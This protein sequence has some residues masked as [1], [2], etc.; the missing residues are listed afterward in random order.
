M[1]VSIIPWTRIYRFNK[2]QFITHGFKNSAV[3]S[4]S[5]AWNIIPLYRY[6]Y[7]Y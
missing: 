1:F 6:S 3:C 7:H 2:T 4:M 5:F